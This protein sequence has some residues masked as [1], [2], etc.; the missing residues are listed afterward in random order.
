MLLNPLPHEIPSIDASDKENELPLVLSLKSLKPHFLNIF[1]KE[2]QKLFD[3]VNSLP[4]K[5]CSMVSEIDDFR[6][7][8]FI[9]ILSKYYF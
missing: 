7:G 5:N 8:S 4:Y 9:L 3:W 1:P 6:N 2:Q